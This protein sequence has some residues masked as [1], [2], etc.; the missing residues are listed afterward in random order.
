M[1]AC[2]EKKHKDGMKK[3]R[4]TGRLMKLPQLYCG[5]N[6]LAGRKA[7]RENSLSH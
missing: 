2:L 7:T 5:R 6:E 4:K 3:F 1:E